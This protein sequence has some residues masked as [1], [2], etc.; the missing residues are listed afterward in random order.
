M[1]GP[2]AAILLYNFTFCGLPILFFFFFGRR[3]RRILLFC[4]FTQH[5]LNMEILNII[6]GST[7]LDRIRYLHVFSKIV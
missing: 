6:Y 3:R 4:G 1:F 2:I 7:G 5:V